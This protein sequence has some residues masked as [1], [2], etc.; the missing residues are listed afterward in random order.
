MRNIFDQYKSYEN[1]LT[2]ALVVCLHEEKKLLDAFVSDFF[3]KKLP[4]DKLRI[5]E[6]GLPGKPALSEDEAEKRGLPDAIIYNDNGV[7]LLIESKVS[8]SLTKNQLLRHTN[9]ILRCGFSEVRGLTI[10]TSLPKFELDGWKHITWNQVYI[11]ANRFYNISA[12]ARKL[13]E[14]FNLVENKMVN[15]EYLTAGSITQFSGIHFNEDNPMTYLEGK[16]VMR[17][18]TEKIRT[19]A[20]LSKKYNLA[21]AA[22]GRGGITQGEVLWDFIPFAYSKDSEAFTANPHFTLNIGPHYAESFITIPNGVKGAVRKNLSALSR[23]AFI[24]IVE[25]SSDAAEKLLQAGE[26]PLIKLVQRRYPSQRA[27]PI[28]DGKLEFDIRTLTGEAGVKKQS[29]WLDIVHELLSNKN[30][31]IQIQFGMR[32]DYKT[33]A[34][35]RSNDADESIIKTL[36][37]YQKLLSVL[38]AP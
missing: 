27:E 32:F 37:L 29:Q 13:V 3:Q 8:A 15:D 12:W 10:C 19:R 2:H 28:I 14:Y 33:C 4:S 9:T 34:A 16:R 1:R 5:L 26:K 31:N 21:L 11:W 24:A 25:K 7:A 17:L 30:S 20:E 22:P 6:Q 18:L 38:F 35:M 23:D 36:E